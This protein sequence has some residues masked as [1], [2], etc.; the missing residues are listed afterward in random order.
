MTESIHGFGEYVMY[1]DK[2]QGI[3]LYTVLDD[4]PPSSSSFDFTMNNL[5]N[6]EYRCHIYT[7]GGGRATVDYTFMV[8]WAN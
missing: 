3:V 6:R 2:K 1:Q 7:S 4:M 8:D 5:E